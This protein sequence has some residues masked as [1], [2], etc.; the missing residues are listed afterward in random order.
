MVQDDH[1]GVRTAALECLVDTIALLGRNGRERYMPALRSHMHVFEVSADTQLAIARLIGPIL[2]AVVP[3]EAP[4][5]QLFFGC[6]HQLAARQ[7]VGIRLQCVRNFPAVLLA[8]GPENFGGQLVETFNR[9][10]SAP[11][12]RPLCLRPCAIFPPFSF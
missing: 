8:A 1:P 7:D 10:A 11:E 5:S 3:L 6:Y 2:M 9:F 4:D 12:V